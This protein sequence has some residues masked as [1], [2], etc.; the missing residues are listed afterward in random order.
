[1]HVCLFDIDGTL[2]ASGGAGKAAMEA[3]MASAF[4]ITELR[5]AVPYSGRTDRAIGRDLIRFHDLDEHPRNWQRLLSAYQPHL[6]DCLANH[7]D[8]ILPGIASLFEHTLST[9]QVVQRL[10][11]S[12][13]LTGAPLQ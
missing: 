3:A 10:L 1:M 13:N 4:G 9:D 8:R 12:N 2:I 7:H 11:T 6:P 5:A